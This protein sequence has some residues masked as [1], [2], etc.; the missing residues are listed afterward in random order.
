MSNLTSFR[1]SDEELEKIDLYCEQM[2]K[3]A[4]VNV[5]RSD[6]IRYLIKGMPMNKGF[7]LFKKYLCEGK[8]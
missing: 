3:S 1:L 5:T 4:G 6:V 7:Q 2:R 8:K